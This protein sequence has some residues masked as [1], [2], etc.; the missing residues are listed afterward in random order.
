MP[1]DDDG[2]IPAALEEAIAGRGP[3]RQAREVPLH[4][5]AYQNPAGVTLPEAR[6]DEIL[7][8]CERAGLAGGRGRPV[9]PARLRRRDRS[10]AAGPRRDGVIYVSTFSKTFAPGLRVGWILAPHAVREKLVIASE[11]QILCPSAFAQAAVASVPR[12]H[13]VARAAQ[14]VPR[15]LPGAARRGICGALADLM[16]AGTRWTVPG[17]GFYIWLTLPDG[18]HSKEMMPRAIA[19]RVAY[20]PGHRLLRGR[21]GRRAHAVCATVP[22]AGAHP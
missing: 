22:A 3:G 2:L 19:D 21:H 1:M 14:D 7:A 17:G 8:I 10:G 9:R 18:L 6:R 20:V 15:G 13:A 12:D 16:P 5:P 11:A 4:G